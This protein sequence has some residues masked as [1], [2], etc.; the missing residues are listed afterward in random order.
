MHHFQFFHYYFIVGSIPEGCVSNIAV[1]YQRRL[2]QPTCHLIF[3]SCLTR[4]VIF[5]QAIDRLLI[6]SCSHQHIYSVIRRNCT[7]PVGKT[8]LQRYSRLPIPVLEAAYFKSSAG[9]VFVYHIRLFVV[10]EDACFICYRRSCPASK[11][12]VFAVLIRIYVNIIF[13]ICVHEI[14]GTAALCKA[15]FSCCTVRFARS[16]K[17]FP[18]FRL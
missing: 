17:A 13:L 8:A 12:A 14:F 18:C 7:I 6:F 4:S 3:Y 15:Y 5:D 2:I 1:F 11:P 16:G 10:A 9:I